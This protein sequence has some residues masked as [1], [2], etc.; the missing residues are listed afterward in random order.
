[1]MQPDTVFVNTGS[2]ADIQTI[3]QMSVAKGEE[4]APGHAGS[5]HSL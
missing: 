3:R 2:A 1:M 5:H 4:A